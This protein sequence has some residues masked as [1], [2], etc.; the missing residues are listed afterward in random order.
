MGI[1]EEEAGDVVE[2]A[3][4]ALE[5]DREEEEEILAATMGVVVDAGHCD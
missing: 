2:A 4:G 5:E 3:I 1:R